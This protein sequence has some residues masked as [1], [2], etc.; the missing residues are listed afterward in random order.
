[1]FRRK[2]YR[3]LSAYLFR[4]Y[5][6][7]FLLLFLVSML[8][9]V[10]FMTSSIDSSIIETQK[11]VTN[12]ISQSISRYLE[13]MNEFSR[14]LMNSDPFKE[15][16]IAQLPYTLT[17]VGRQTEMLQAVYASAYQMF[18]KGYSI[19]I[20][21]QDVYIWLGDKILVE[22]LDERVDTYDTYRGLGMA[23]LYGGERNEYLNHI[24]GGESCSF[25]GQPIICCARSINRY[26]QFARPQAMLE[27]QVSR[28]SFEQE[29]SRLAGE[30]DVEQLRISVYGTDGSLLYGPTP[31]EQAP[32][33]LLSRASGDWQRIDGNMA[34]ADRI[35]AGGALVLYEIPLRTYY[36]PLVR[37]LVTALL[38]CAAILLLMV[39][40]TYS[41][42]KKVTRPISEMS[43]QLE[44]IN[45]TGTFEPQRVSTEIQEID[46]M[47]QAVFEMNEKLK[48]SM[49]EIV[50]ARTSEMQSQLMALQSQM[51]P[52][53]LY[54]TLA[55][56]GALCEQQ[57]TREASQICRNLSQMMRYVSAK[58]ET[59]TI[60]EEVV[61]LRNYV[62][63]MQARFPESVV[64]IDI[65]FSMLSCRL[66][67]MVIQPLCE[68]SYKYARRGSTEIW[69]VGSVSDGCWRVQ[70][71]DNGQGFSART[72]EQIMDR[73]RRALGS[74]D[75]LTGG[76]D[77]MGLANIYARLALLY[78][79]HF[80]FEIGETTGV[81]IGGAL[82]CS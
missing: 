13:D 65:P 82:I 45:L 63:I 39:R 61:F 30:T 26:N 75:V 2:R 48:S 79:N 80:I 32:Q 5:T 43:G 81:T 29:I 38:F 67:K 37:F 15:A 70:V 57:K 56:I 16:V 10:A 49:Q 46:S 62:S 17:D 35:F 3:V 19:G 4:T 28:K 64:H 7:L 77:G 74:N 24:A 42:S 36:R 50:A 1:M 9:A 51:Q 52:H 21:T 23:M 8:A 55:V 31:F 69:V 34:R 41:V 18:E 66:P 73:C 11:N 6:L 20:V 68:N 40:V 44:R 58:Q 25:A 78:K 14:S 47:S 59:V 54:N 60:S 53:F 27:V 12:T 33:A 76:V 72:I 71:R 22:R